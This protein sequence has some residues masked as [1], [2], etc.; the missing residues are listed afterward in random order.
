MND[1]LSKGLP[2]I[3]LM[4]GSAAERAGVQCGDRVLIANGQRIETLMEYVH[5]RNVYSDRL[6]LTLLRGQ[7]VLD[8]VLVFDRPDG[9]SGPPT[10]MA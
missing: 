9:V 2:V 10:A 8:M 3:C 1:Q 5:A 7:Q 4:P 6:E